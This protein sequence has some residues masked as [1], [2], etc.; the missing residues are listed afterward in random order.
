[1]SRF[2]TVSSG[3][4][5]IIGLVALSTPAMA[6]DDSR[7][8]KN[9]GMQQEREAFQQ[10]RSDKTQQGQDM[11]NQQPMS[12]QTGSQSGRSTGMEKMQQGQE[13]GNQQSMSSQQS[14][15]HGTMEKQGG[16]QSGRNTGSD[17]SGGRDSHLGPHDSQDSQSSSKKSMKG[18]G[19]HH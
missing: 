7:G 18:G 5:S 8:G 1:M 17:L 4:L 11:I 12:P 10:Q 16:G 14:D 13:M 2:R 19:D 15:K 6:A 3:L 9:Q